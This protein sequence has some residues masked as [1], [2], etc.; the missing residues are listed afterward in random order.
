MQNGAM[1]Q[2][3]GGGKGSPKRKEKIFNYKKKG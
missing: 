1:E 2:D 3:H